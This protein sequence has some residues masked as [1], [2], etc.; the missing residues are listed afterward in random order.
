M[1]KVVCNLCGTSYPENATQCPICGYARSAENASAES[2]SSTYTYVKGGRFSKANVKKRNIAAGMASDAV[3]TKAKKSPQSTKKAGSRLTVVLI[4]L[5]L[6]IVA[7]LGYVAAHFFFPDTSIFGDAQQED[8]IPAIEDAQDTEPLT[9]PVV[10]EPDLSCTSVSLSNTQLEFTTLDAEVKLTVTTEPASTTD[11]ITFAS[12]NDNVVSV[13]DNGIVKAVGEGNAVIT[14]TC[15]SVTAECKVSCMLPKVEDEKMISL[16]RKEITFDIEG[17]SWLLYSG[18]IATEDI[19]WSSDDN[20]VA[21][22]ENGKVTAVGNGDTTVYGLYND[23][24]VSCIIHCKF[25]DEDNSSSGGISEATGDESSVYRLYNPYGMAEDVSVSVG[26]TF[27]LQLVDENKEE[28]T[29]AQWEVEDSDICSYEDGVVEAL[30]SGT[31]EI[32]VTYQGK[33]YT[34]IVR[35]S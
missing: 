16:N 18:D 34:S 19:I 9:D 35:V 29:D 33:S 2:D 21:T 31:T 7:I 26:D 6:A 10:T 11:V 4:L 17:Q 12:S 20:K 13:T 27:I 30:S 23:Q 8:Q 15:G 24:T 32:T 5:L 28:V 14:V 25:D 3:A 1:N 22:I